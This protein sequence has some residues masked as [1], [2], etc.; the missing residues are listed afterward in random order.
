MDLIIRNLEALQDYHTKGDK[1]P[2]EKLV[3]DLGQLSEMEQFTEIFEKACEK[4]KYVEKTCRNCKYHAL[5]VYEEPCQRCIESYLAL[6]KINPNW[7]PKE[8]TIEEATEHMQ[9]EWD[10]TGN[11]VRVFMNGRVIKK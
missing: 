4:Y 8:P 6:D 7:E 10:A 9:S 1:H 5:E 11:D 3:I 2:I